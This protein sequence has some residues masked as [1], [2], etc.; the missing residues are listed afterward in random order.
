MRFTEFTII[1]EIDENQHINY[2]DEDKRILDLHEDLEF[3]PLIIIRFNPDKY[4]NSDK[5][6]IK[7]PFGVDS[8]GRM[9]ILN[10]REYNHRMYVLIDTIQ[11]NIKSPDKELTII[12][13]FYNE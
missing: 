1:I 7:T 13:L 11:K 9:K 8:D 6:V 3:E 5:L 4:V 2:E 12:K 10:K